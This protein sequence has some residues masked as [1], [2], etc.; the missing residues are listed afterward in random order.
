MIAS[1]SEDERKHFVNFDKCVCGAYQ[2]LAVRLLRRSL[3]IY[4]IHV[5]GNE[6]RYLNVAHVKK[7]MLDIHGRETAT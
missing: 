2:Y 5:R 1:R 7:S 4:L 3:T 6:R